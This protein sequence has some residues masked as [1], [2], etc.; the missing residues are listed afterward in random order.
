[1]QGDVRGHAKRQRRGMANRLL[2]PKLPT[3]MHV[4]DSSGAWEL[5]RGLA[6]FA[7]FPPR[8]SPFEDPQTRHPVR[9]W[10]AANTLTGAAWTGPKPL[11]RARGQA[12]PDGKS[13]GP[14]HGEGRPKAVP[15]KALRAA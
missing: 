10:G 6:G 5:R 2:T 13:D 4:P 3:R 12:Y 8:G 14:A 9:T 1:M 7:R 15:G 11:Y